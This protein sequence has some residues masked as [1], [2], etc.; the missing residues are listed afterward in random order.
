MIPRRNVTAFPAVLKTVVTG[1]PFAGSRARLED[2]GFRGARAMTS[3]RAGLKWLLRT[4]RARAGPVAYVPAYTIE[5]IPQIARACGYELVFLDLDADTLSVTR[6]T[7]R[8]AHRGPGV[9]IVTHYFG[10]P[11]D[12]PAVR[13]EADALGIAL[14]EDC[15]HAPGG[16][17]GGQIVGS[18]GLGGVFSFETRKPLNGL[19]GGLVASCDE[20]VVERM[21]AM[22]PPRSSGRR[23]AMK[24]AT[25]A[26]EW[27]ALRPACFRL[28][29]PVL[30]RE[31]GK[32]L[33]V[34]AYRRL[35]AA[36]R[37]SHHAFSDFQAALVL[38]QMDGL[39]A[40]VA[41]RRAIARVYNRD[42]PPEAVRPVSPASRPH[43]YYMYVIRHP[44]AAEFGRHL[45]GHG[46]DCGIGEE[47]LPLCAPAEVA[48]AS[49]AVASTV[50]EIPMHD[51]MTV[52]DARRVCE[53]AWRFPRRGARG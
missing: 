15:A 34:S 36:G 10:L 4:V 5:A 11:A 53:V 40:G 32:D 17:V 24:L 2:W 37:D 43:H 44:L 35:H 51:A 28:L 20:G 25:A 42:L 49:A 41:H 26:L 38:R 33:L 8:Q 30:H 9:A 23:D 6:E 47:V 31:T 52:D 45:R 21:A 18:F 7:L 12:M 46:V 22:P 13:E 1:R 3:G 27:A 39:E 50:V 14:V 19:G 48:P 16:R 29:A